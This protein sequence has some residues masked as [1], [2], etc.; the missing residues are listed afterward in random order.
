MNLGICRKI[1]ISL[2]LTFQ[3]DF[4]S[5]STPFVCSTLKPV[6]VRPQ[7][8]GHCFCSN[9]FLSAWVCGGSSSISVSPHFVFRD[10]GKQTQTNK[11]RH[12]L[13]HIDPGAENRGRHNDNGKAPPRCSLVTTETGR[14]FTPLCSSVCPL[15]VIQSRQGD[16]ANSD[17]LNRRDINRLWGVFGGGIWGWHDN[18]Y[19]QNQEQKFCFNWIVWYKW[20]VHSRA[21]F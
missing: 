11:V 13:H 8:H 3:S 20:G 19:V 12:Y 16:V 4:C 5:K 21:F 9:A 6:S 17:T 15:A 18:N 10:S 2:S 14:R 7:T 1:N